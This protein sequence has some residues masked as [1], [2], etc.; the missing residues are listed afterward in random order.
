MTILKTRPL[1]AF[2]L[3]L[4]GRL[5]A[6]APGQVRD[7]LPVPDVLGF[8]TLKCDFHMH[9]VFSDGEVW[10][11]TRVTEA[12]RDGLDAIAITDHVGHHPH[13]ADVSTDLRRVF[14]V[15]RPEAERL[16]VILIPGVEVM[17]GNTHFNALFVTDAMGFGS[18]KL[19]PALRAAAAQHAFAFWNHPGWKEIPRWSELVDTAHRESLLQG[20]E[21]VNGLT[22]YPEVFPIAREKNLTILANSDVHGPIQTEY[23]E[24]TR[25]ITLVLA[26]TRDAAG[27]RQALDA[28]RTAAWVNGQVWG[29]AEILGALWNGSVELERSR[30]ILGKPGRSATLPV[31]NRSAIPFEIRIVN[32]PTWLYCGGS[33]IGPQRTGLLQAKP[34]T[35]LPAGVHTVEMELEVTN[36]HTAPNENLR[37][38]LPVE[39]EIRP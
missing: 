13:R 14:E 1:I 5:A 7:P 24:R 38:R 25:P 15:A 12:W 16:G 17:E 18:M 20:V 8:R 31:R 4:L 2:V 26:R 11:A 36:L 6:V 29:S 21:L 3:V 32:C 39:V 34:A 30:L 22:Y 19:L 33:G 37:V 35:D 28:G 27:I 9:S 23:A 10:P